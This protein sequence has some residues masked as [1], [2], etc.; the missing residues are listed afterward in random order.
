MSRFWRLSI[1]LG[2]N[3]DH[4]MANPFGPG[5]PNL[6]KVK[7]DPLL[8]I[9]GGNE[10]LKDRAQDYATRLKELGK[11]IEYIE[12]EGREHGF[13]TQDPYSNVAE[14]VMRILKRFIFEN[15]S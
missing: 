7:L 14:E 4:P 3:R 11:K 2:H 8:V 13:F 12:F 1:P 9:V 10:L 15:S 6:E 5:S